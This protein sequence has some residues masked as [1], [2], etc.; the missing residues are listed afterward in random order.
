MWLYWGKACPHQERKR[1]CEDE[2]E[3]KGYR[4]EMT[5]WRCRGK[6]CPQQE[7]LFLKAAYVTVQR[8]GKPPTG[9]AIST[10]CICDSAEERK[11]PNRKDN[12]YK[13]HMWQCRGK[14]NSQQER[15]FL[16]AAYVTVQRKGIPPTGK[17]IST[18]CICG[19]VEEKNA[20]NRKGYFYKLHMWRCRGKG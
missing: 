13:L 5:V 1:T 20:P 8:K 14:E 10:S 3:R 16:Q 15:L 4:K 7:R 17:A 18:S 19:G 9:K 2:E 12:F 11:T 6:E